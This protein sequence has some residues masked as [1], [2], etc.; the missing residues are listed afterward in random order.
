M[1]KQQGK[2]HLEAGGATKEESDK[3]KGAK[4][5]AKMRRIEGR[6]ASRADGF[7]FPGSQKSG[8]LGTHSVLIDISKM[9]LLRKLEAPGFR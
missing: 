7:A 9:A 6:V 1:R 8:F 3:R 4:P 5:W 2:S